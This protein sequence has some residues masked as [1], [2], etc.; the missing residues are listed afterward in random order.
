MGDNR[1]VII[2]ISSNIPQELPRLQPPRQQL[3][4]P[5]LILAP[6]TLV[7]PLIRHAGVISTVAK[8]G[9]DLGDGAAGV[10]GV[11]RD[12][13][14]DGMGGDGEQGVGAK[15]VE[16]RVDGAAH[17]GGE[18]AGELGVVGE[19][20]AEVGAL[21]FAEGREVRVAQF[22]VLDGEVVDAL[23]MANEMDRGGHFGVS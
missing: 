13:L 20:G 12:L 3:L 23:G 1:D 2:P 19:G 6:G 5:R 10:A 15:G 18:Q 8:L 21:G 17:G 14:E 9:L 7:Q 22:F 16:A 4:Q 11:G